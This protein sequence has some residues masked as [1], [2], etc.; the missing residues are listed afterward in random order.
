MI[1][2]TLNGFGVLFRRFILSSDA[3]TRAAPHIRDANN[4][5][6]LWNYFVIASLPAWL[7]GLWSVGHQ[8]NMAIADCALA[9]VPG[10]RAWLL[11]KA[12]IG[13]DAWSVMG[14]VAHGALY[15]FPIFLVALLVGA[16][17]ESLFAAFR[18]KP[19]DEGLLYIAWFYALMMPA[20]A[21]LYPVAH[22]M[23][24]GIVI[25]KLIYGGSG[26]YLVNPALFGIAFLVFSY[27]E[28]MFGKGAWV[29]V[30]GYD[31]PT[32]LELINEEGGLKVLAAV[33]YHY[34]PMFIG[35]QPGAVG[36][37]SVLGAALGALFLVWTGMASWR[38]VA[39][40][41]VGLI[42]MSFVGKYFAPGHVI[43]S[44]PWYWHLVLGGFAF[45]TVFIA[46]DPV[47]G[48]MTDPG[49]WGYGLLV[50]SLTVLIRVGSVS[51]YEGMIFAILLASL[52]SPLIDYVVAER[53]I[54]RR[55]LRLLEVRRE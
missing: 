46:T 48:P 9:E 50:G 14:C 30:I 7:I 11:V 51:Y 41:V 33:D 32:A 28:L 12:G 26:R 20:S 22:G 4:V 2:E 39:G 3:V 17:W 42:A 43:L 37:V 10:W 38:V 52:F 49:R 19:L 45:G 35:D 8:T 44:I 47:A 36:V 31:Q 29:P 15:F 55:R 16:F 53:N 24:V 27:P 54:R 13:F 40:A 23:A 6:R 1:G 25:G 34:W 5:Q 21:S 18:R